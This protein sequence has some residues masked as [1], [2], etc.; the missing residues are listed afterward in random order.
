MK[1][2]DEKAMLRYSIELLESDDAL[3]CKLE[4]ALEKYKQSCM[5]DCDDGLLKSQIKLVDG[6]RKALADLEKSN[7]ADSEP[8]DEFDADAPA[9]KLEDKLERIR[10]DFKAK[11]NS[12]LPL[13]IT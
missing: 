5:L 12:E 3:S 7:E 6:M 4:Q 11:L 13:P 1:N 10:L 8:D 2:I 9:E